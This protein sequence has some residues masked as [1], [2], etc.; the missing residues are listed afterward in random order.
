MKNSVCHIQTD[1]FSVMFSSQQLSTAAALEPVSQKDVWLAFGQHLF[2]PFLV[3]I[4]LSSLCY[5]TR[6]VQLGEL[7]TS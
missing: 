7:P 3:S 5:E 4:G 1:L 6:D 2:L